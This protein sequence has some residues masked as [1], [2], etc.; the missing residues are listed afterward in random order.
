MNLRYYKFAKPYTLCMF[1][2]NDHRKYLN[3]LLYFRDHRTYR[4]PFTN[5]LVLREKIK[6]IRHDN[7]YM[8]NESD[9]KH[10][11]YY[12]LSDIRYFCNRIKISDI[13]N[14]YDIGFNAFISL[15]FIK[16][17]LSAYIVY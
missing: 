12:K 15:Y 1:R 16:E 7:L 4:V 2:K 14:C 13:C 9:Y 5:N 3:S 11:L 6:R 8:Y 10:Y 17:K